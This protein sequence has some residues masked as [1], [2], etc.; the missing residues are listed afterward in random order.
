MARY[1]VHRLLQIPIPLVAVSLIVFVVLRLTGDPVD[2]Y[3]PIEATAEQRAQIRESLGLNDPVHLQYLRYL[4]DAFHGDFGNSLRFRRPALSLMLE[5]FPATLQLAAAGILLSVLL[6]VGLGILS[7]VRKGSSLDYFL[8]AA[9]IFGQSLPG[10]WLGIIL[11]MIFA[12]SLHV[13]PTSGMGDWRHLLMPAVTVAS[14]QFPQVML[15]VRSSMLETMNEDF[16]RVAR[17]K[18]LHETGVIARH[19]LPNVLSPVVTSVG[20]QFGRLMGGAVITE[21]V[22]SWPGV[23]QFAVQAVFNRDY[24]VVQ[25]A[26]LMMALLIIL[27]N[28][29]ADLTNAVLDPRIRRG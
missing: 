6:G 4:N 26:I 15:L 3:L 7:A 17:A 9:A 14:Y 24:P 10:F 2:L 11:I 18:G 29:V 12:V 25:A 13:L 27:S 20:L 16:V 8:M 23:G 22:F 21:T 28:L 5:R 1:I 19:V